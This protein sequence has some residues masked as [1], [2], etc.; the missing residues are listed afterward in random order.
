MEAPHHA[1]TQQMEA[2]EA[3]LGAGLG[4]AALSPATTT[5]LAAFKVASCTLP[6][7]TFIIIKSL[8]QGHSATKWS[9]RILTEWSLTPRQ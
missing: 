1:A 5:V 9:V 8:I 2:E 4:P 6:P 3:G 7:L